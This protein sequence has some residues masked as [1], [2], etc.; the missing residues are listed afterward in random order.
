MDIFFKD[1]SASFRYYKDN[2]IDAL[3][4]VSGQL[5]DDVNDQVGKTSAL[6]NF[7]RTIGEVL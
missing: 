7:I 2:M 3:S 6:F 5:A 1:F 4:I